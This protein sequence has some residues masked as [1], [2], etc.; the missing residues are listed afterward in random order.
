MINL[1][2]TIARG[3]FKTTSQYKQELD[4]HIHDYYTNKKLSFMDK[5]TGIRTYIISAWAQTL[6]DEN[7][8]TVLCLSSAQPE[9]GFFPYV[10][11]SKSI[12]PEGECRNIFI[13][14]PEDFYKDF[15]WFEKHALLIFLAVEAE[16]IKMNKC[17]YE[18]DIHTFNKLCKPLPNFLVAKINKFIDSS[19]KF[20][21][22]YKK[23]YGGVE[24]IYS[25]PL[26][27]TGETEK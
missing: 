23:K 2:K 22:D 24:D 5:D 21:Q 20:Y 1:I 6:E 14:I 18:E 11:H 25:T 8:R 3:T 10:D 13:K 26:V 15:S 4:K 19:Y 7:F 12:E 16:Y 17:I 9:K 27:D